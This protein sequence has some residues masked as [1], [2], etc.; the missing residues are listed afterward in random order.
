MAQQVEKC[1]GCKGT[2]KIKCPICD[3]RGVI[4]KQ[5][6]TIDKKGIEPLSECYDC[7]GTG[8]LLCKLCGG[9]GMVNTDKTNTAWQ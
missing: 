9:V 5:V 1:I 4:Q 6:I 2:G 3:G 7:H 8:K